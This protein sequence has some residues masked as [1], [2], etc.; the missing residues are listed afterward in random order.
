MC[1][2]DDDETRF[3]CRLGS[4]RKRTATCSNGRL[5]ELVSDPLQSRRAQ[6]R[7][8]HGQPV[9]LHAEHQDQQQADEEPGQSE[10]DGG[11]CVG[12]LVEDR[13]GPRAA[14][15]RTGKATTMTS[16]STLMRLAREKPQ[17]RV[18][19]RA[20]SASSGSKPDHR[21]SAWC[22]ALRLPPAGRTGCRPT[23]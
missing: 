22:T 15:T 8:G 4:R 3:L 10:V 5:L 12:D 2:I 9:E 14:S 1:W 13:I 11:R 20:L 7:L 19:W 6:V 23:R 18:A 21:A 16:V 17:S